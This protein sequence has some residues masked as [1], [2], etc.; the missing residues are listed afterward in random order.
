M[1]YATQI[2]EMCK[3]RDIET[4][5]RL[6]LLCNFTKKRKCPMLRNCRSKSLVY[7]C[8]ISVGG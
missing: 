4:N 8:A 7:N 5:K 6:I 1:E 2:N 3:K